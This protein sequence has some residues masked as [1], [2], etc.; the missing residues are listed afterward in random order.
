MFSHRFPI[1]NVPDI[2][3]KDNSDV[4][5]ESVQIERLEDRN[6][7]LQSCLWRREKL[8]VYSQ[9]SGTTR[10]GRYGCSKVIIH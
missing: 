1:G 7:G 8:G 9:Y 2:D 5:G 3:V 6:G 4:S 10:S